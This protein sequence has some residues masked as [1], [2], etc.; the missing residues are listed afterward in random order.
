MSLRGRMCNPTIFSLLVAAYSAGAWA[1]PQSTVVVGTNI[2]CFTEPGDAGCTSDTAWLV[3]LPIPHDYTWENTATSFAP[4]GTTSTATESSQ[5]HPDSTSTTTTLA[6]HQQPQQL[7]LDPSPAPG[8]RHPNLARRDLPPRPTPTPI[9]ITLSGGAAPLT[10]NPAGSV[11][12]VNGNPSATLAPGPNGSA[13]TLTLPGGTVLAMMK[14]DELADDAGPYLVV[15]QAPGGAQAVATVPPPPAPIPSNGGDDRGGPGGR[16]GGGGGGGP[17]GGGKGDGPSPAEQSAAA[18]AA[19]AAVVTV[20]A[21][22][23]SPAGGSGAYNVLKSVSGGGVGV[24]A[25]LA[26][27]GSVTVDGVVVAL[28]TDGPSGQTVV[29]TGREGGGEATAPA[30]TV[31]ATERAPAGSDGGNNPPVAVGNL[32]FLPAGSAYWI[33]EGT[34]TWTVMTGASVTVGGTVVGLTTDAGGKTV[35]V[36]NA[37]NQTATAPA[38]TVATLGPG[39]SGGTPVGQASGGQGGGGGGGGPLMTSDRMGAPVATNGVPTSAGASHGIR[40][41]WSNEALWTGWIVGLLLFINI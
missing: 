37:G 17:G 40:N 29:V 15:A 7:A 12:V 2:A 5:N 39:G 21:L 8:P 13:T 19:S 3:P 11:Y 4:E 22:E 16:G 32:T 34:R 26:P 6:F 20:G 31:T 1:L 9:A 38:S 23:L 18:A 24:A 14:S 33:A 27:G 28:R 10:L 30:A 36:E 41:L 35:V 25:T